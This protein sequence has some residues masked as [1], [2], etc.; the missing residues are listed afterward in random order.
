MLDP[1]SETLAKKT[2]SD[3]LVCRKCYSTL[4]ITATNCRRCHSS[5]LRKKHTLKK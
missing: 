3:K 4:H 5:N 1:D 2:R